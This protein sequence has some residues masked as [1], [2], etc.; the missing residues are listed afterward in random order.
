MHKLCRM[1]DE[2]IEKVIEFN[3]RG[4][5]WDERHPEKWTFDDLFRCSVS[6][7]AEALRTNL[8]ENRCRKIFLKHKNRNFQ[9]VDSDN[10]TVDFTFPQ[11]PPPP[12][13]WMLNTSGLHLRW[14]ISDVLD[15]REAWG[16]FK[17]RSMFYRQFLLKKKFTLLESSQSLIAPHA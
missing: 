6:T 7:T 3:G 9:I 1:A 5:V 16:I 8:T 10:D 2:I 4:G 13:P 11:M 14:I 12:S 17:R 15:N